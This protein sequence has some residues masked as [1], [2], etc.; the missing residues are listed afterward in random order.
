MRQLLPIQEI[1][2]NMG[3]SGA[4]PQICDMSRESLILLTKPGILWILAFWRA[5]FSYPQV[6]KTFDY[7]PGSLRFLQAKA[8]EKMHHAIPPPKHAALPL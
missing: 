8:D 1:P 4:T 3:G 2:I 7:L 6:C 5:D